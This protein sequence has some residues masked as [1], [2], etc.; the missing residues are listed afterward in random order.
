MVVILKYELTTEGVGETR[1]R[2]RFEPQ[3]S[4]RTLR[5]YQKSLVMCFFVVVFVC[6]VVF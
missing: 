5:F 4:Q 1:E 2:W 3:R 6:V